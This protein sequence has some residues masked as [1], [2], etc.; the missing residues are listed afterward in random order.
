MT[1]EA[2]PAQLA[3][4]VVACG[5]R[6]RPRAEVAG[7]VATMLRHA[8]R[9]DVPGPTVD[10]CGTGGDRAHTVNISTMAAIVVAAAGGRVVKHGN[11]AASSACGSADLL[12]EL[13]VAVDLTPAGVMACVE[14]AGI[15]FC[16]APAVPSGPAAR[17]RDAARAWRRD[18]CSTSSDHWPTRPSPAPRRSASRMLGWPPSWPRSSL[19]AACPPSSFAGRMA[20]TSSPRRRRPGCGPYGTGS[21]TESRIEPAEVGLEQVP[22]ASTARCGRRV[23]RRCH[24]QVPRRRGGAGA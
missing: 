12:E 14:E 2:T 17:G 10:T 21:V 3:G 13:G 23:Q 4:F 22:A 5:P 24:P 7:L 19:I 15:G 1:G 6:A 9:V 8:T 20:S 16:F 11:R 18:R